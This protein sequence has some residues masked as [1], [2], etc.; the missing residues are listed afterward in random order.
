[1]D[2][3]TQFALG[4]AVSAALLGKIVGP[5]KAVLI[6]GVLGTLP[7]LDILIPYDDPIDTFVLHRGASHAL[8]VHALVTP[9]FG[10]ALLRLFKDLRPHRGLT[11]LAVFLCFATHA[12]IDAATVYGTRLFWPLWPDPVGVGS[13]FIIDPLYTVPLLIA[14]V[15]ALCLSAW[16]GQIRR[17]VTIALAVSTAYMA[18]T[19]GLQKLVENR[20][21]KVFA[22]AGIKTDRVFAIASPFNTVL[23]KVIGLEEDRYHNLYLSF[24]DGEAP[25][26]I[27]THQRGGD[28]MSCL[29]GTQAMRKLDWFTHGYLRAEE[30]DGRIVVAD[31]RMGLTPNYVFQFAIAERDSEAS[32]PIPPQRY[33]NGPPTS[34]GD[35]DWL[36]ARVGG[37]P[38]V[39]EA[40]APKTLLAESSPSPIS[41]C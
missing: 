33:R 11:Y 21:S 15:W 17:V 20:A 40:E 19:T 10:E 25:P 14:V 29:T 4:A 23:W 22:E 12:L 26:R 36:V 8:F 34:E 31:L 39:R 37:S 32:A 16:T 2:S 38:A 9:L 18:G 5:R 13:I 27:Y 41:A 30:M 1:M 35:L 3:V 24:L 6:G 7:D 28:L